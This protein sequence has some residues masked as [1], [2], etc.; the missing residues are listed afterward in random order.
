V[1]I[2][3]IFLVGPAH[4]GV[5]DR[6][7]PASCIS[8]GRRDLVPG[9]S[10]SPGQRHLTSDGKRLHDIQRLRLLQI[11]QVDDDVICLVRMQAGGIR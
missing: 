9:R 11:H 1:A 3:I 6:Q 8:P 5:R 7:I 4:P 2:K 10:D